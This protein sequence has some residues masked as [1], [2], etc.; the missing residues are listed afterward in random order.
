M[1]AVLIYGAPY[2]F[3]LVILIAIINVIAN[4]QR[5]RKAPYYRIRRKASTAA[6]RW[7][8][9]AVLAGGAILASFSLRRFVNPIRLSDVLPARASATPVLLAAP[10]TAAAATALAGTPAASPPT[11]TP[12]QPATPTATPTLYIATIESQVTPPANATLTITGIS[13]GITADLKPVSMGTEFP[14]GIPRIYFWFD[15]SNMQNGV[16]WSPVLL[17]NDVVIRNDSAAWEWGSDGTGFYYAFE[18]Q[19]GWPPGKYE[20]QVFIGDHKISSQIFDLIS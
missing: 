4:I 20:V 10:P 7:V 12:T 3:G 11:I 18:A 2:L 8:I 1:L 5:A 17:L 19:G 15:F 6:W 14:A 9:V 16:S 13:S